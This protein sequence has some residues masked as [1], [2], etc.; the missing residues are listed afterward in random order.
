VKPGLYG[1][2]SIV[3][4][5]DSSAFLQLIA[6]RLNPVL[7]VVRGKLRLKGPRKLMEVFQKC[8]AI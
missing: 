2:P 1:T 4:T 3:V 8:F 5:A 6:G 7:A